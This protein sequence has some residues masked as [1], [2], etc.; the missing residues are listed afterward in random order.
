M[1]RTKQERIAIKDL[2]CNWTTIRL[3][4]SSACTQAYLNGIDVP[5]IFFFS[6]LLAKLVGSVGA[7]A[8]GLA[9]GKEG[10][11]VHAGAHDH[12]PYQNLIIPHPKK[13]I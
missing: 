4:A 9:V 3:L 10:P 8:G 6:T 13:K 5:G 12:I 1:K 7:V 2:I 11:F